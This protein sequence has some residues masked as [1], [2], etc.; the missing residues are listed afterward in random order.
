MKTFPCAAC[1]HQFFILFKGEDGKDR[2]AGCRDA[3]R[4]AV[5]SVVHPMSHKTS[6]TLPDFKSTPGPKD[7]VKYQS[8]YAYKPNRYAV[9][10]GRLQ[11]LERIESEIAD[12]I[13]AIKT[14]AWQ[15]DPVVLN[16]IRAFEACIAIVKKYHLLDDAGN[17]VSADQTVTGREGE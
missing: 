14:V 12:K 2:C 1:G 13:A 17:P 6:I 15:N 10:R 16:K 8:P 4:V 9:K 7:G 3:K 11:T 5:C